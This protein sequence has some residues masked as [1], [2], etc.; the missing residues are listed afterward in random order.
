MFKAPKANANSLFSIAN[1]EK[2]WIYQNKE[3]AL[4]GA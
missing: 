2:I 3:Q 1:V 4:W